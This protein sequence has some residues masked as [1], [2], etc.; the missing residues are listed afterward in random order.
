[1]SLKTIK[2][3]FLS[4]IFNETIG[5][6]LGPECIVND[7]GRRMQY[8]GIGWVDLDEKPKKSDTVVVDG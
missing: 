5:K 6:K 2:R 8:V 1:M 7:N 3:R 4:P